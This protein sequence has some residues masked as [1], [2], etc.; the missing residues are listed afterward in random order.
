MTRAERLATLQ[1]LK[2]FRD[3]LI[4]QAIKNIKNGNTE[5]SI[6]KRTLRDV[7]KDIKKEE[8]LLNIKTR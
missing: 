4:K 7:T 8:M 6:D 5:N 3:D 2:D 1:F